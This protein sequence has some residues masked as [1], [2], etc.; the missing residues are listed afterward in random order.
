MKFDGTL[1][2]CRLMASLRSVEIIRASYRKNPEFVCPT[3]GRGKEYLSA[4]EDACHKN[5]TLQRSDPLVLITGEKVFLL[6]MLRIDRNS[7]CLGVGL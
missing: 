5:G 7:Q 6:D 1:R 4:W 3:K 2:K